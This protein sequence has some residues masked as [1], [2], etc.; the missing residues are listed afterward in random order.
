MS[1][2]NYM[3]GVKANTSISF[4]AILISTYTVLILPLLWSKLFYPFYLVFTKIPLAL[5]NKHP[6]ILG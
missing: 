3:V 4:E 5:G 6:L 1:L 2:T